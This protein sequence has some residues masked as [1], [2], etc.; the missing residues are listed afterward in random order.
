MVAFPRQGPAA[1]TD[2]VTTKAALN[3]LIMLR[4][5][6]QAIEERIERTECALDELIEQLK[7]KPARRKA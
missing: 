7:P 5:R 6:I 2:E 1:M 4:R 3:E